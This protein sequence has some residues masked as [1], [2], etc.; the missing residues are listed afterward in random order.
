MQV[1][2]LSLIRI[3][4]YISLIIICLFILTLIISIQPSLRFEG[5][6]VGRALA[7]KHVIENRLMILSYGLQALRTE[8]DEEIEENFGMKF[9]PIFGCIVS[10]G[11]ER[12][13]K[14]YNRFMF[15]VIEEKFGKDWY[16]QL[17][18]QKG[19]CK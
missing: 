5:E 11:E 4:Q 3:F 14:S 19:E 13:L 10:L 1:F 18:E 7:K 16:K 8:C 2:T 9:I 15:P 12:Q 6:V 17:E